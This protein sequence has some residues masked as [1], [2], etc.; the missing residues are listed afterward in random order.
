[1]VYI[2][3]HFSLF[4]EYIQQT[5]FTGVSGL[6]HFRDGDRLSIINIRQNFATTSKLI[7]RFVPE[8]SQNNVSN[9]HLIIDEKSIKWATGSIPRDSLQGTI[10]CKIS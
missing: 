8:I 3:C 5:H 7:G 9:G 1:M 2:S 10:R 6:V 4:R